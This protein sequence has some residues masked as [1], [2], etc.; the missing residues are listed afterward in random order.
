MF[1]KGN[2]VKIH[3]ENIYLNTKKNTLNVK[4]YSTYN[5]LYLSF[6]INYVEH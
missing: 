3:S 5:E 2:L 6:F 1:F 4:K